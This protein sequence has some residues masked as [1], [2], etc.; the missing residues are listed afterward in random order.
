[1]SSK[2]LR[3]TFILTLGTIISKVLGLFYVIPF[4][5]IVGEQ[6]TTLYQYSYVPYTIFISIATA[7]IPLAISKFIAKYNALEEYAV[8]R[9]LFKSGLAVMLVTGIVSFL[10]LYLTAPFLADLI[11]RDND[12]MTKR[13][14]VITVTRAVSFALIIVPIMS[15]I[16]GFFQ[17]HQSMGPSAVSQVVEQIVRIV[18]LLAGAFFILYIFHGEM[19]EAVSIATFA[20]FIGAIGSLVILLWY[21]YKRKPYLDELLLQDKGTM[22]IS[23]RDMY[24]E[25]LLYAAPFVFVGIANPLFQFIDQI[26]F[27][28][29][30]VEIGLAKE[31]D[32]A[33]SALNFYAHKL[34][35]IP[36]SL[37]TAFSLTLVPNITTAYVEQDVK[38]MQRMLNQTFQVLLFI[39]VPAVV[40]MSLLAEPISTVFYGHDLFRSEVLRAYTPVALLFALYSVT[41][42]I[43]QGINEQRFTILSLLVG[44]LIKLSLN[45]PLIKMMETKGAILATALGYGAAILINL[46]VIKIYA[47]YRYKLIWRRTLL[48]VIFS[49]MML[50]GAG[51]VYWI[52]TLF[53]SPASVWQSLIIIL[54]CAFTGVLIYSFLGLRSKL[55]NILFGDKVERLKQK[56]HVKS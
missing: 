6:G 38:S 20:A 34:V 17:G 12:Q 35:I 41:A 46:Y 42:A 43:M 10:I 22:D 14:D 5:A 25:I 16:R 4:D 32:F 53:L 31:S 24:K 37:A 8:G 33:F 30:M 47:G 21:W 54:V 51:A 28:R 23:L 19:V 56:L 39:T 48:I 26:T 1:M 11:I 13:E 29:A 50:L 52:F 49:L 36:V 55:A 15:L 2:L 9:K 40:G 45:I 3:G 44:L 7:G 27:N 18:F